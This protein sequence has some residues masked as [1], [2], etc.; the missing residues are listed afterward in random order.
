MFTSMFD[1]ARLSCDLT[2]QLAQFAACKITYTPLKVNLWIVLS[3]KFTDKIFKF[4]LVRHCLIYLIHYT[5]YNVQI[6][7]DK[8]QNPR[9]KYIQKCTKYTIYS[10][11]LKM[12]VS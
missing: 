11:G 8:R 9:L 3:Q 6:V 7:K 10:H 1:S 12:G 4:S 5:T 2:I